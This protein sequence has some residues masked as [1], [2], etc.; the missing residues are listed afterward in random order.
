M[1]NNAGYEDLVKA[2]FTI[3]T[4][5]DS[6]QREEE[7]AFQDIS[8][9]RNEDGFLILTGPNPCISCEYI[10]IQYSLPVETNGETSIHLIDSAGRLV[11]KWMDSQLNHSVG[12]HRVSGDW[13]LMNESGRRVSSGAYL[14]LLRVNNQ[15]KASWII[16]LK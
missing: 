3:S 7:F 16:A 4:I 13:N 10:A 1:K 14:F 15:T 2:Q 9:D 12:S 6:F 8:F 5:L 11:K